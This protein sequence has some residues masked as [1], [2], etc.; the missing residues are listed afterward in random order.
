MK[1]KK[2]KLQFILKSILVLVIFFLCLKLLTTSIKIAATTVSDVYI[3]NKILT[4]KV[5][6]KN[7]LNK[8]DK[9]NILKIIKLLKNNF[10][11]IIDEIK[12]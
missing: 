7:E 12:N 2:N 5:L 8:K 10:T 9:E 6:E 1:C 4:L 3:Y 11:F